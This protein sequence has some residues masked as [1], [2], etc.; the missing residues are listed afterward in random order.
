MFIKYVIWDATSSLISEDAASKM[1][2]E[3]FCDVLY[4]SPDRMEIARF[5]Y[6]NDARNYLQNYKGFIRDSGGDEPGSFVCGTYMEMME[7]D[8]DGKLFP[9]SKDVSFQ[10]IIEPCL[11]ID[12]RIQSDLVDYFSEDVAADNRNEDYFYRLENCPRT[13][14]AEKDRFEKEFVN[15]ILNKEEFADVDKYN[16]A[17]V[18]SSIIHEYEQ[19]MEVSKNFEEV[20]IDQMGSEW[21][22][23]MMNEFLTRQQNEFA[24]RVGEPS[25]FHNVVKKGKKK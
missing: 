22:D 9:L 25:L 20:L 11:I 6:A 19:C 21:F 12:E 15:R 4:K 18:I 24:W 7:A 16:I 8:A 13:S 1:K 5:S 10:K 14:V 2:T 23:A 17:E 3:D